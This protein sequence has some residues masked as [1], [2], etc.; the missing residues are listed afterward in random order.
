[1]RFFR[2]NTPLEVIVGAILLVAGI[3]AVF[4]GSPWAGAFL[5]ILAVFVLGV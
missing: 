2:F 1:M 4:T 3:G 5:V